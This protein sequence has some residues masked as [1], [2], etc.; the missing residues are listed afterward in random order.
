MAQNIIATPRGVQPVKA[1]AIG[2]DQPQHRGVRVRFSLA[3]AH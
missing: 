3:V 1:E 2:A